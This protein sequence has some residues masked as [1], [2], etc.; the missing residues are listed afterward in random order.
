VW[1]GLGVQL[2]RGLV[3][4][5]LDVHVREGGCEEVL[6]PSVATRA[7]LTGSAHL[8]LLEGKMYHVASPDAGRD[9]LLAPRAEPHLAGLHA[10]KVL[11]EAALPVR[12]VAAATAFRLTLGGHGSGKGGLL[13]LH[14]FPTVEVYTVCRPDQDEEE[15]AHA[16][17]SAE[18]IL[19]RLGVAYRRSLRP[20]PSLSHAAAKTVDLDV[21]APGTRRWLQVAA[22]STFTNYQ[23]R[24]TNTRFRKRGHST[25]SPAPRKRGHSTFSPAPYDAKPSVPGQSPPQA[26]GSGRRKKQNVPFSAT[27]GGAAVA[28]P[29]LIA[30]ILENGQ[31]ADG[32]VRLPEALVPYVET[33]VLRAPTGQT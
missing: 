30:A 24:R 28:L 5:M 10:G 18:T 17:Q 1:R 23:A 8:P 19:T 31:Q 29:R 25:F 7:A 21:W 9:L 12:L 16:V 6:A 14:E 22:L 4:L 20:A 13:R 27:V 2:V 26:H 15:L 3:R 11:D 32:S 33:G